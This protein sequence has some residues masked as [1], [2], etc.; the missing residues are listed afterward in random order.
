MHN[1]SWRTRREVAARAWGDGLVFTK[2]FHDVDDDDRQGELQGHPFVRRIA[3]DGENRDIDDQ[4]TCMLCGLGHAF[5]RCAVSP[6]VQ[7]RFNA[8]VR[9]ASRR[10]ARRLRSSSSSD[11]EDEI[12]MSTRMDG[13]DLRPTTAKA[14][15][16]STLPKQT[17]QQPQQA[18]QQLSQQD[19]TRGGLGS[20]GTSHRA[21]GFVNKI[22]NKQRHRG[23]I[24][25][26]DQD[27]ARTSSF[28]STSKS[29][30]PIPIEC[31]F[32]DRCIRCLDN[33]RV[34][35]L[36][37]ICETLGID[38]HDA[39]AVTDEEVDIEHTVVGPSLGAAKCFI[40]DSGLLKM[41]LRIRKPSM[42]KVHDWCQD[43]REA[44]R[45]GT[46]EVDWVDG[47][48]SPRDW[49]TQGMPIEGLRSARE[50][51]AQIALL[52]PER[53]SKE[54]LQSLIER[55]RSTDDW[56]CCG[57]TSQ[58]RLNMYTRHFIQSIK[59]EYLHIKCQVTLAVPPSAV[60]RL[61]SAC[62]SWPGWDDAIEHVQDVEAL[63]KQSGILHLKLKGFRPLNA[64]LHGGVADVLSPE[65]TKPRDM[66]ALRISYES[67]REYIVGLQSVAWQQCL[68]NPRTHVRAR[69]RASGYIMEA[70]RAMD[71]FVDDMKTNLTL[72]WIMDMQA[73]PK[74]MPDFFRQYI[75]REKCKC[76]DNLI[77]LFRS[78][79]SD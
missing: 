48:A 68:P 55:A 43:T 79:A 21:L 72:I 37:D 30:A 15:F 8:K 51:A 45:A 9:A 53:V 35:L 17:H 28:S 26:S 56:R 34:W 49:R 63:D 59:D 25:T 75:I 50:R 69:M 33:G 77:N 67:F 1:A 24:P 20:L 32:I 10:A 22:R 7:E 31:V 57:Q 11:D 29:R 60:F 66:C 6:R 61:I 40:N 5:H 46:D 23:R 13:L 19:K 70:A 36:E 39:L 12:D 78:R 3:E 2:G 38:M 54:T 52:N 47:R 27:S 73:G 16:S 65:L 44:L 14:V 41:A 74:P 4:E 58:H 62:T 18:A 71:G 76:M 64:S 42:R